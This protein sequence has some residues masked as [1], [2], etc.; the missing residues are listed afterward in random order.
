MSTKQIV[1]DTILTHAKI[2]HDLVIMDYVFDLIHTK[3]FDFL[4]L[5][6]RLYI[7]ERLEQLLDDEDVTE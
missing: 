6:D 2:E 1:L 3:D 5:E 4:P 7:T